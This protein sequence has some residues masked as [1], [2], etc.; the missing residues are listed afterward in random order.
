[1]RSLVSKGL[2]I[3]FATSIMSGCATWSG[4]KK[5]CCCK[6]ERS[7]EMKHGQDKKGGMCEEHGKKGM[8][9]KK[10]ASSSMEK[11]AN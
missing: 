8:H 11:K 2:M 6:K 7:C 10:K 1:M 5:S 3:L 4:H 9:Q